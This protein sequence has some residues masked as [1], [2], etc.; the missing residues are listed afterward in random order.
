MQTRCLALLLATI[1]CVPSSYCYAATK[2]AML[3]TI[4]HQ[5]EKTMELVTIDSPNHKIL[6]VRSDEVIFPL[7]AKTKRFV[8]EFREFF[9]TLKGPLNKPPAGLAAPQVGVPLRIFMMQIPKGAEKMRKD[10]YGIVPPTLLINPSYTPL[11]EEGKT[12]DWEGCFSVPDKMGEVYRYTA[13]CYEGYMEDGKKV[14]GIAKGLLAR[15]IQHEMGHLNGELFTD[16]LCKDCRFGSFNK[17][18][19]IRKKEMA[20]SADSTG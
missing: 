3:T 19:K 18:M 1:V 7:D 2:D 12:K 13:V 10:V 14:T 5:K 8:A 9:R 6:R 20:Q 17:M 16:H 11:K 4:A 15:I